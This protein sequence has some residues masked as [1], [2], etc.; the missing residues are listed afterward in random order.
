MN[1][2]KIATW[3]EIG[4]RQPVAALVENIDLVIIRRENKVSV[5]YGRCQHRGALM[6]DGYI[7]GDNI[8]CGVHGWDYRIDTGISAYKNDEILNKFNA[9]IEDDGVYV[10]ADEIIAWRNDHPQPYN[11]DE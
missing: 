9:W 7:E 11:R 5:L 2:V 1:K 4:D 6:A 10:D 8:I 3:S